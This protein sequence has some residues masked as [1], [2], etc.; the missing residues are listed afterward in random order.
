MSVSSQEYD[1]EYEIEKIVA[2]RR[3]K[4]GIITVEDL[5]DRVQYNTFVSG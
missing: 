4:V 5:K 1:V 3:L 2:R